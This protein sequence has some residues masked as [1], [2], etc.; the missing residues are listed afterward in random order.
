MIPFLE[1]V[2]P[3]VEPNVLTPCQV[4][5]WVG[6]AQKAYDCRTWS[7]KNCTPEQV[8]EASAK[9]ENMRKELAKTPEGREKMMSSLRT[10]FK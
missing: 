9:I 8:K 1:Y 10:A 4:E 5:E 3:C 2:K 7:N 6:L